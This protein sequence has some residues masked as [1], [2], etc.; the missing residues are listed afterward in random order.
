MSCRKPSSLCVFSTLDQISGFGV[1]S[2]GSGRQWWR[3]PALRRPH[4]PVV[5]ICC[6]CLGCMWPRL[7]PASVPP[8]RVSLSLTH[9]SIAW[10]VSANLRVGTFGH[11]QSEETEVGGLEM[12]WGHAWCRRGG[13]SVPCVLLA[14]GAASLPFPSGGNG[15]EAKSVFKNGI[16]PFTPRGCMC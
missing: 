9:L 8:E 7:C 15:V 3:G 16:S 4:G 14:G 2:C 12:G 1:R 13:L 5:L 11:F 6:S 10:V